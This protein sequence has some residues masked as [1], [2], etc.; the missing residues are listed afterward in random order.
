MTQHWPEYLSA[1]AREYESSLHRE[2]TLFPHYSEKGRWELLD[3][4]VTS[5][6][7]GTT[8]EHGN[9]TAGFW[10]GNMWLAALGSGD[11]KFADLARERLPLLLKRA[12]DS[13]THDLGFLFYPSVVL[14]YECGF[15]SEEDVEPALEAARMTVRRFNEP[16]R[17]IQ[18]FGPVGEARS[19]ETSTVDT[20]MN[21]PLLWWAHRV[22]GE[23]RFLDV[24]RQH[25]RTSARLLVRPD[26]STIHLMRLDPV[27]GAFLGEATLQG[28]SSDSA[29]SRGQAWAV[30]GLAWAYAVTGEP[31]LLGAAERA[32]RYFDE[33]SGVEELPPWD[34]ADHSPEPVPDASAAAVLALGYLIL[35]EA[36]PDAAVRELHDLSGRSLLA[37]VGRLA[38]NTDGDVDGILVRSNYSVPHGRGVDGATAWGD[39]YVGLALAVAKG[40]VPID[41]ML[42]RAR[43]TGSKGQ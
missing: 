8:Y 30:S 28:A 41:R 35:A 24:A 14:G 38:I 42:G 33:R 3:V 40:V 31:E 26:A 6:W 22:T 17:Y 13:T 29:W 15:L 18:A 2:P 23:S 20:M 5:S 7:Q 9:W 32:A 43:R 27:S 39:F 19:S 11:D 21:L 4:G 37:T 36:H 34:F 12:Q 1:V 10:F 16:G 25:A